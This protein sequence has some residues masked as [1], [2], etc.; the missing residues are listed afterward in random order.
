MG[1][2][3]MTI[4]KILVHQSK[5]PRSEVRLALAAR[6]ARGHKAGLSAHYEG[7]KDSDAGEKAFERTLKAEGIQGNWQ[8]VAGSLDDFVGRDARLADLIVVGQ[9]DSAHPP[10]KDADLPGHLVLAA[11]RPVL[12]VP[13]AGEF[14][15]LGRRPLI[16]WDG[17]REANRAVHDALPIL[18]K[19]KQVV[20]YVINPREGE[21]KAGTGLAEFLSV[22][23]ISAEV[24]RTQASVP[25][26][27][28]AVFGRYAIDTG[29]LLM[30]AAADFGADLLVMGAY[31]HSR[32]RELIL[33]GATQSILHH[34]TIPV[35]ASH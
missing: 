31:G 18:K 28:S 13:Y 6:L 12:I 17:T 27:E 9:H 30:S 22:H 24:H 25:R 7:R 11:G 4:R 23:G 34:M 19:S 26:D 8:L 10:S 3:S 15:T 1:A 5:D 29:G 14:V 20:I 35:L 32:L 16:A 21:R 2:L 33:G